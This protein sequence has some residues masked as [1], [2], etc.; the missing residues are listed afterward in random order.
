ME[1]KSAISLDT[2][3]QE[4]HQQGRSESPASALFWRLV[5]RVGNIASALDR[6][7]LRRLLASASGRPC[8]PAPYLAKDSLLCPS[9]GR[10]TALKVQTVIVKGCWVS[11][12]NWFLW[13]L[14]P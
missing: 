8:A 11:I 7:R 4:G 6:K 3:G 1:Q 12:S 13:G 9:D 14:A 2:F 10:H 5:A